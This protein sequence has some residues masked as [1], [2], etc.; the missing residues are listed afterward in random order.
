MKNSVLGFSTYIVAV[1]NPLEVQTEIRDATN[2]VRDIMAEVEWEG[3]T[4]EKIRDA[5]N[6]VKKEH[7][8]LDWRVVVNNGINEY[9]KN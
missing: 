1:E 3:I 5:T 4:S 6:R 2:V 9:L 7:P 8:T